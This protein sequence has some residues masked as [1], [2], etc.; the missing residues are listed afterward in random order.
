MSEYNAKNYTEQGGEVIH[1]GGTLIIEEGATVEGLPGG[2]EYE[3]PVASASELGGVKIGE[4]LSIDE[5]G[6]LSADGGDEYEMPIAGE[7]TLGGVKVGTGLDISEEGVLSV[8]GDDIDLP[9]ATNS[10]LGMVK[11]GT[12]LEVVGTGEIRFKGLTVFPI[13][14]TGTTAENNVTVTFPHGIQRNLLFRHFFGQKNLECYVVY[15][16]ENGNELLWADIQGLDGVND[17]HVYF[18]GY[19]GLDGNS[20]KEYFIAIDVKSEN[21]NDL[22]LIKDLSFT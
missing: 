11:P 7:S 5:E 15:K 4:G 12:L 8:D 18:H 2:D 22:V 13:T 14:V 1:I 3:L 17:G 10:T 9:V 20:P 19:R 21:P 6:V 16:D